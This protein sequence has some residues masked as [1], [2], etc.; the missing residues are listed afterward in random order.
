MGDPLCRGSSCGAWGLPDVSDLVT[1]SP[2]PPGQVVSAVPGDSGLS[3]WERLHFQQTLW[4]ESCGSQ[5]SCAC[6]TG[7]RPGLHGVSV[8]PS[9]RPTTCPPRRAECLEG[10]QDFAIPQRLFVVQHNSLC[11]ITDRLAQ[12]CALTPVSK[13]GGPCASA[14][15]S[16]RVWGSGRQGWRVGL[17]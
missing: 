15:L 11:L 10:K 16:D 6:P 2:W 12:S 14:S 17:T 3:S 9:V 7:R 13:E 1:P 5:F 8:C 4:A